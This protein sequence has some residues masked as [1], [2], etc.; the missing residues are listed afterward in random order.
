MF[1]EKRF[2]YKEPEGLGFDDS[3][4]MEFDLSGLKAAGEKPAKKEKPKSPAELAREEK[5]AL[6]DAQDA[7]A[8]AQTAAA[9]AY[10]AAWET[11][12]SSADP[13]AANDRMFAL[14]NET[15]DSPYYKLYAIQGASGAIE[16]TFTFPDFQKVVKSWPKEKV[17][18]GVNVLHGLET[19]F[20]EGVKEIV[21]DM[22][23]AEKMAKMQAAN[24]AARQEDNAKADRIIAD[25]NATEKPNRTN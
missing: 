22:A 3:A 4:G 19:R 5:N 21:Q 11:I 1:K 25:L 8:D 20:K 7:Y 6:L 12:N 14:M 13:G 10:N 16:P 17:V 2:I 9:E 15:Q 23:K 24:K 18:E